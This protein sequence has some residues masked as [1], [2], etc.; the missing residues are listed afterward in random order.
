MRSIRRQLL[1]WLLGGMLLA[2]AAAAVGTY[3]RAREDANALFDYQLQEM[4]AS[5]TGAPFAG[6]PPASSNVTPRSDTLVVQIW[7]RNGVELFMSQPHRVL[8]QYAQLGFNTIA[9]DSGQWRVFSTLAGGQVVQVAQPMSA[10][11]ELAASLALRRQVIPP[12][13]NWAEADPECDIDCVPNEPREAKL[14]HVLSN[15]YAFGGNN[16]S[17]VLSSPAA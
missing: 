12:T 16:S 3:L 7:D 1:V 4:A 5:L 11:R 8:P 6:V 15:S 14:R 17:L 10:R 9:A 13:W 2:I